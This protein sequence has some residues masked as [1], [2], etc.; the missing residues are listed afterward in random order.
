MADLKGLKEEKLKS[1]KNEISMALALNREE[2]EPVLQENIQRYIGNYV[3]AF[4]GDW[5]I[6]LNEV[7]PIIQYSLPSI[8]FRNP[9][10]FLKPR[11]KTFIAKRRNPVSGAMEE[12]QLDSSKSAKTQEDILNYTINEMDYKKEC[13]KTLLDALLFPFGVMWHGYKGD[14]GMTEESSWVIK[15]DK[16]FVKRVSPL[17]F[18]KDPGVNMANLDEAR[19]VARIIDVPYDDLIEDD[20]L[21]VDKKLVKGKLGYGNQIGS[22]AELEMK[23]YQGQDYARI[24]AGRRAMIEFADKGFKESKEARFVQV[25]EIYLRPSKKEKREGKKGWIILMCDEQEKPL[26][27]NTW[28]IKAEGFPA[29]ILQFNELPDSMFG[30]TDVETYKQIA[31]MKNVVTNLQLRNGQENSKIWVALAKGNASEEEI[32]HV[33]R[34]EQTIVC[35]EGDSIEGKMKVMSGGGAA[36][37][38]LYNLGPVIDR[39]LQEKSGVTDLKKGFIQSG[40]ESAT[41]VRERSAGGAARPAYRQDLMAEFLKKSFHYVNQLNKQFM[42]V[43]DAVRIVGSLDLEWSDN[44]SK[45]EIQADVDVEIDVISM[46][47]E[48]PEKEMQ[49]LQTILTMMYQA[50]T[51]PEIAQKIAQEGKTINLSPIIEQLLLRLRIKDP[52]VFRNIRPEESEGFVSVQQIRQ[53]KANVDS[54]LSQ[55]SGT[56]V[57]F[58]PSEKDDHV[59]KL[60]VY[61]S[62]KAL[63]DKAGQISD[64]LDQLIQMQMALLQQAQE[65]E[66][67]P[68][69]PVKLAKPTGV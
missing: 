7:Y 16:V 66:A 47:P 51:Q 46:L 59:A 27:V 39:Q 45:E 31:D 20:K 6:V 49:E 54:A 67:R 58:P 48:N 55:P 56:P 5:D 57:P 33:Q 14:F 65:Q 63:L 40:E 15:D 52:D 2:L 61:T 3:P 25:Y 21:D 42:P 32:E 23:K 17:R 22:N 8:F 43:K 60:E 62:I 11:N 28:E 35:F 9:R 44:P 19:W 12:I 34:G 4:G 50:M 68:N 13:R 38:E 18:L 1:L 30:L 26:R 64:T 41:S 10:A 37:S 24:N 36:S 53:A 69:Q 29:H